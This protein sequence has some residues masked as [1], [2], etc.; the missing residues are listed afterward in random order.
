MTH[1]LI[2]LLICE[3]M[4]RIFYGAVTMSFWVSIDG[5]VWFVLIFVIDN[6]GANAMSTPAP[7]KYHWLIYVTIVTFQQSQGKH[8]VKLRCH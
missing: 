5:H 3:Y 7:K 2:W 8:K 6:T 4:P 1:R